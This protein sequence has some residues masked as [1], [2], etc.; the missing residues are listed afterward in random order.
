MYE[1]PARTLHYVPYV[2]TANLHAFI[3]IVYRNYYVQS[4]LPASRI[5]VADSLPTGI[6]RV[7]VGSYRS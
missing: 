2:P 6:G 5:R 7:P 1:Q 3:Y 4:W